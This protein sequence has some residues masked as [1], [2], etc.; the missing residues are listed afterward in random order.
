[1]PSDKPRPTW[2]SDVP[3]ADKKREALPT[4]KKETV[5]AEK[6]TGK[7]LTRKTKLGLGVL[8][9]LLFNAL[10]VWV[11]YW[12]WPPKPTCLVLIG[13]G[14]ENN[15][16]VP[17]NVYGWNSLEGLAD[18]SKGAS[19]FMSWGSATMQLR[20]EPKELNKD[21]EWDKG[22]AD[23]KERTMIVFLALHGGADSQG[24][25]LLAQDTDFRDDQRL[26]VT[27]VLDRLAKIPEDKK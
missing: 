4:W 16:A 2:R 13:A 11:I 19:S 18:L 21:I 10:L 23:F 22:L 9:F 15:L 5:V 17:H 12:L 7:K 3:A 24:P 6:T 14:Y 20:F 8:A 25:F 26:R 27:Q 1:M